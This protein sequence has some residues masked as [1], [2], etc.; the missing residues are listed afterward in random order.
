M[1]VLSGVDHAAFWWLYVV[2]DEIV[3]LNTTYPCLLF[4]L[5]CPVPS[6]GCVSSPHP[7]LL[8]LCPL[9]YALRVCDVQSQQVEAEEECLINRVSGTVLS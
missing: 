1:G 8:C 5:A 9:V 2:V 6:G 4:R 7:L 3:L